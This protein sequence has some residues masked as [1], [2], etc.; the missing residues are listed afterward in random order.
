MLLL[1][2][3][4]RLTLGWDSLGQRYM[5][6][7]LCF[8]REQ[9]TPPIRGHA[10]PGELWRH[11]P[12]S[13]DE[14]DGAC[15]GI[16]EAQGLLLYVEVQDA[17]RS[18]LPKAPIPGSRLRQDSRLGATIDRHSPQPVLSTARVVDP[19]AVCRW[20]RDDTVLRGQRLRLAVLQVHAPHLPASTAV[21]TEED[22]PVV[23]RPPWCDVVELA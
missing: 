10:Q 4:Q 13:S 8:I 21:G 19:P 6:S 9:N 22:C 7:G 18:D 14:A 2:L 3:R 12:Q 16:I 20:L 23:V 17:A 15:C 5:A 1:A 11:P